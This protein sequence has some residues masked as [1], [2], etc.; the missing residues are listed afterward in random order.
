MRKKPI[1][2]LL[3]IIAIIVFV[4]AALKN[5]H[6]FSPNECQ[7]CHTD[8]K[9]DPKSL[10]EPVTDICKGC[11][12]QI[13]LRSSHPADIYPGAITVPADM[14]LRDGMITCATCHDIHGG[15]Q[16]VFGEKAYFLRRP[17]TGR[18][19]CISCHREGISLDGHTDTIN[20][21]HIG[22]R[23][24]VTNPSESLDPISKECISCHGG[25]IGKTA[26]FKLGAGIWT[27]DDP[28]HN[29]PIGVDYEKSRIGNTE[30]RLKH[31]SVIDKRLKLFDGKVGCGT[32]HDVYSKGQRSLVMSNE[33][34]RICTSC[35]EL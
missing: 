30:A 14:P 21:A 16:N 9:K 27:H 24:K 5:P 28:S 26:T 4:Y 13:T 12:D 10:I 35:H 23:F 11:H 1:L 34:S 2:S 33:G 6:E 8:Y 15:Y 25:I 22:S 17:Y 3:L 7:D 19:F 18:S 31:V 29:H 20:V 32:C